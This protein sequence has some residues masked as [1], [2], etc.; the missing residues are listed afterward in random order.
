MKRIA[1]EQN[2]NISEEDIENMIKEFDGDKDGMS[3]VKS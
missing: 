2:D 1:R 3:K